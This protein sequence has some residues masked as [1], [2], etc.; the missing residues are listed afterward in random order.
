M[1]MQPSLSHELIDKLNYFS[2][3]LSLNMKYELSWLLE[4]T[5]LCCFWIQSPPWYTYLL[6]SNVL[7]IVFE[8]MLPQTPEQR[9]LIA[10]RIKPI[11]HNNVY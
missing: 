1:Y 3:K 8:W 4:H 11:H 6:E 5:L 9:P 10:N 2:L 7:G